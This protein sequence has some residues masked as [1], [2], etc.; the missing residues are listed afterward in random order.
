MKKL[1]N[2]NLAFKFFVSYLT[3]VS[4]LLVSFY[5]YSTA[6]IRSFYINSLTLRMEE[7]ARLLARVLPFGIEGPE[8]D[9]ICRQHKQEIASRITV[10]ARD[11]R[12]L[13]DSDEES[14]KME[15][16]AG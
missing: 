16:H 4:L 2:R 9:S 10:I 3:V 14:T 13:C 12:V 11:G 7:E 5:L 1:W 15:N 6:S 8:F